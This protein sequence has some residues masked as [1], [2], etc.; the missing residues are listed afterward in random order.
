[1]KLFVWLCI[2]ITI[3]IQSAFLQHFPNFNPWKSGTK[4]KCRRECIKNEE[5]IFQQDSAPAPMQPIA[6]PCRKYRLYFEG[7]W[8]PSSLD[9]NPLDYSIWG[10]LH[11]RACAKAHKSLESLHGALIREWQWMPQKEL[12]DHFG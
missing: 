6:V 7:K 9:P 10:I 11:A 8:P 2:E 4:S 1:M 12:R 3:C 5:W